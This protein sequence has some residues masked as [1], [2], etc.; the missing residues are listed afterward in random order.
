MRENGPVGEQVRQYRRWAGLTQEEL[1]GKT[2]LGVRTIRDLGSGRVRRPR[3]PSLR[4]LAGALGVTT[5]DLIGATA[6]GIGSQCRPTTPTSPAGTRP[7][8]G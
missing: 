1:A 3:G 8:P 5:D 2:G 4:L 6:P 7:G